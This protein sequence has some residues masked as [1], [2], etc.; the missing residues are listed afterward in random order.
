V[1]GTEFVVAYNTK[2]QL[3]EVLGLGGTVEVHSPRDLKNHGVLVH[4]HQLTEVA[5][6]K[7][8]TPPRQITSD[9]DD[10]RRLMQGLSLPGAGDPESLILN[11][12]TIGGKEVPLTDTPEGNGPI[13]AGGLPTGPAGENPGGTFGPG[14]PDP[15]LPPDVPAKTGGDVLGQPQPVLNAT[16]IDVHF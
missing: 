16:G 13:T 1:R 6:G 2:N 10:Y 15:D 8:P 12:P 5:K 3:S 9:D 7:F 4:D 11:D 14:A